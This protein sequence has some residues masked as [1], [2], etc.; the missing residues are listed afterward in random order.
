MPLSASMTTRLA[1]QHE[2]ISELI[3]G[4]SESDLKNRI[5]PD[6]WSVF[7]N[8]VHL[9]SYQPTVIERIKLVL[10]GHAPRFERYVAENDPL[11]NVYLQKSLQQLTDD[12]S[13]N[14]SIIAGQLKYLI[15]KQLKL[16]GHH[17]RFGELTVVQWGE[18]FLLHEAHHLY[19]IMQLTA[20][21]RAARQ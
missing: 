17:P 6:K 2:T 1:H 15:E 14:R 4:F 16:S 10:E 7:E 5:N 11:F 19:T 18:F 12:I 13:Y 21:L 9:A 3:D 8:I 20:A